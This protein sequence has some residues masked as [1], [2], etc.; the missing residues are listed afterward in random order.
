MC[1][2]IYRL[3]ASPKDTER[4]HDQ[5]RSETSPLHGVL[6]IYDDAYT[7]CDNVYNVLFIQNLN[8]KDGIKYDDV[9]GIRDDI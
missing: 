2:L 8:F 7:V 9:H 3:E 1:P 5:G 6:E 4:P